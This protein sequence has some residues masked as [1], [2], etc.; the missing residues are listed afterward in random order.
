MTIDKTALKAMAQHVID[1]E[2]T[3]DRPIGDAWN[4]F[5]AAANPA[6]VLALLD[7]NERLGRDAKNDLI[8]YKAAIERQKEIRADADYDKVKFEEWQAS[9]HANYCAVAEERDQLKAENESLKRERTDWQAECLKKGFEYVREPDDHYVLADVPEMAALLGQ[10]LGVEVRSKDNDD[11]GETVSSLSEQLEA[12]NSVYGRAYD[13]EKEVEALRNDAE[14]Y[15]WC[16][17]PNSSSAL[18]CFIS[19][20]E[21]GSN[22]DALIDKDMSGEIAP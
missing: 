10:V 15:R 7:E 16:R 2:L 13:L 8:A 12:C 1:L 20:G 6:A 19:M 4:E 9:H 22:L 18:Y 21:A 5:E 17:R 3:E 14:R 11:Y